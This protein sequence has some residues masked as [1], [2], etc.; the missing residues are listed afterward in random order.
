MFHVEQP[1]SRITVNNRFAKDMTKDWYSQNGFKISSLIDQSEIDRAEK[2]VTA[3]YI[4]PIVGEVETPTEVQK[5]AIGNLAFLLLLQ[6]SI[7]LTRA[8]A[9]T[10]TGYNSQEADA[11]AKLQ[12][13][14]S[15]CHLALEQL[16]NTEGANK[17]AEIMD[18]CKIYFKTNFISL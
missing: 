8:G 2:E 9:K 7:F 5:N 18:I 10:K 16:R 13:S 6:R 11:W 14:A 1:R 12:Q 15:S 17:D 4:V 3:A